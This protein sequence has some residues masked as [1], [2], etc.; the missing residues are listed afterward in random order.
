MKA[1]FKAPLDFTPRL[2][3]NGRFIDGSV[4]HYSLKFSFHLMS[5]LWTVGVKKFQTLADTLSA[6]LGRSF[7]A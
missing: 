7:R 2:S 1:S 3:V 4:R 5:N 6:I